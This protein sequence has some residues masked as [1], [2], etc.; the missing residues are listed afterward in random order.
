MHTGRAVCATV[1][2]RTCCQYG[3]CSTQRKLRMVFLNY[4]CGIINGVFINASSGK[5][6]TNE[7]WSLSIRKN[8]AADTLIKQYLRHRMN[9][10][11]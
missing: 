8:N 6:G 1:C 9:D 7:A 2:K 11:L 5:P 4:M 3:Y 10:Y